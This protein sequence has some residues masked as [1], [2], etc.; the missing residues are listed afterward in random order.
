[1]KPG[2]VDPGFISLTRIKNNTWFNL[3]RAK[4]ELYAGLEEINTT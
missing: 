2:F 3:T 1:M 4:I